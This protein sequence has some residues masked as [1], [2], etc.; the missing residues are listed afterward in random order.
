MKKII[1]LLLPAITLSSSNIC[2]Q[3]EETEQ[4]LLN[5]E[6]LSQLKQILSDMKKGYEIISTGYNTIK[7]ISEGNF[8]LHKIFLDALLEVSPAVRNYRKVAGIINHQLLL[9]KEYKTAFHRFKKDENFS[10]E[11]VEYIGRVYSNLF[12]Q[13][14][15]NLDALTLVLTADRLRMSDDERLIAIDVIFRD[16]QDKLLYLRHFNNQTT[17]LALQ[18]AGEQKDITTLQQTYGITP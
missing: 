3:A 7:N 1:L 16:Q 8:H 2:A 12:T 18:R 9:V 5:V 4:L 17:I 13:S 6:K 10:P 11:E 14:L 15:K